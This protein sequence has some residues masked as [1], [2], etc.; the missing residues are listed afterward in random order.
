MGIDP[1]QEIIYVIDMVA[2]CDLN[3]E[4]KVCMVKVCS[5]DTGIVYSAYLA[6]DE[7]Y[8]LRMAAFSNMV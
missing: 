7:I 5:K 6:F 8:H 4:P 2:G 1:S 3:L